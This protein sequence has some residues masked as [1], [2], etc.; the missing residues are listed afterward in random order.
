MKRHRV[1]LAILLL[2][3]LFRF[4][5]LN[6]DR[7]FHLH[8]DERFL[9][10]V[11]NATAIST[12]LVD[13][14]DPQRSTLNPANVGYQFYV[15]GTLPLTLNKILT[16]VFNSD[17]YND[18]TIQGRLLSGFFDLLIVVL[19]YQIVA[20]IGKKKQAVWAAFFYAI[21][22]LPIQ[23]AHFYTVDSCLNFFLIFSFYWI[24]K[25]WKK[26][27]NR[28]FF[29]FSAV[30]LGLAIASKVSAV[31][32][33][34][35]N[36]ILIAF[37]SADRG[38]P[39]T[40][41]VSTIILRIGM[42]LLIVYLALRCADPYVF[43]SSH[44]FDPRPS[45]TFIGNLKLLKSFEGRNVWYPPAIQWINKPAVVFSLINLAV[46]GVGLPYFILILVGIIVTL[47]KQLAKF[48]ILRLIAIWVIGLFL[49]QSIQFVKT[50]RYF[51]FLYPFLAIFAAV[52]ADYVVNIL[53][54]KTKSNLML[55]ILYFAPLFVSLI[56]PLMFASVYMTKNSRVAASEWIYKNIPNDR[57]IL[58]EYW[59]DALPMPTME[60]YGKRFRGEALAVFD[61]DT[62]EKWRKINQ[63]LKQGD[64]YIL[65]SN[66]AWG[67][68]RTVPEK[69]P[70][71][72][73][74]YQ[75]LFAEKS[76]YKKI[77]E[78]TSYPSLRWLGIPLDFPDLWSEEAFT[79]YDHPQVIIFM[80]QK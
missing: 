44:F 30:S 11:G 6:W 50:M 51:I 42:Y 5:G 67:S 36:F 13:Y 14:F 61:L 63:Q 78:F 69:Y 38:R 75:D 58:S 2:A 34:P 32:I 4:N 35:L 20:L 48:Y 23:L 8:P 3:G 33:F 7:N 54:N 74:F 26:S 72:S 73:R 66:R 1:I 27:S 45:S 46:F 49:Y 18:F 47:K 19:V 71:T 40:K 80:K 17:N 65:S 37:A 24:V 31:Y 60:N 62:P 79:V 52:G 16:V 53:D 12:R 21:A 39:I 70:R 59:D 68:I 15:Y 28:W 25:W 76:G 29:F 10:M 56:W 43:Q 55:K 9:T 41:S 77:K 22:V 64:Y 57:L